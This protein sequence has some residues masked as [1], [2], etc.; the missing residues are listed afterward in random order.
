MYRNLCEI[1]KVWDRKVKD[2]FNWECSFGFDVMGEQCRLN[3]LEGKYGVHNT[4]VECRGNKW[5][6]ISCMKPNL[7]LLQI[8]QG[9][10]K[11][12]GYIH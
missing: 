3:C 5:I 1:C 12:R 2:K 8:F 6:V 7:R 4:T 10:R 9:C 11:R